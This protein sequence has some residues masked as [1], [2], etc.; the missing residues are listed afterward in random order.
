MKVGNLATHTAA[1]A[2][3]AEDSSMVRS[4]GGRGHRR[5]VRP[6]VVPAISVVVYFV[7][8]PLV[9]SDAVG[10]AIAGAVSI[11]YTIAFLLIRRRVDLWGV[12]TSV[13]FAMGCVASLLAGG[14]ALPL[15]LHEAAVTFVLG[16]VLLG[17]ALVRRPLPVGRVF[18]VPSSDR[19]L[20]TA[21]SVMVGSFLVL[22]ALL[23]L[24]LALTLST[25]AYLTVGRVVDWATIG[26][27]VACLAKA[28][29]WLR[30]DRRRRPLGPEHHDRDGVGMG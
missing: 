26:V 19:S 3:G 4:P 22:H 18:K 23:H 10:L 17:A 25:G 15:K 8:R 30:S 21:L 16:V 12:L 14:S 6:F 20:D 5:A 7:V 9:G 28:V 2:T 24:A 1:P 11:S 29:R 13:G 27:A